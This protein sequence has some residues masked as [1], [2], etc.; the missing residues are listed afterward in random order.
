[1]VKAEPMNE[2]KVNF[3]K[4]FDKKLHQKNIIL[5]KA[6]DVEHNIL[7]RLGGREHRVGRKIDGLFGKILWVFANEIGT[8]TLT[9]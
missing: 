6:H 3:Q 2:H 4:A 1:M 9:L 5:L 7:L 8:Y